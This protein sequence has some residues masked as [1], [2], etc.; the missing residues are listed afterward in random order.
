M[1]RPSSQHILE[2]M[3]LSGL[4]MN[5]AFQILSKKLG[6]RLVIKIEGAV[7][8]FLEWSQQLHHFCSKKHKILSSFLRL[9][10]PWFLS[11]LSLP[12]RNVVLFYFALQFFLDVEKVWQ[13]LRTNCHPLKVV[14]VVTLSIGGKDMKCFFCALGLPNSCFSTFLKYCKT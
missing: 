13:E 8:S 2:I 14:T 6:R 1:R 5:R 7:F 11:R 9:E 4:H 12:E 3:T 10:S